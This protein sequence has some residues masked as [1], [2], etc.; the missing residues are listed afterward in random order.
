VSL[1]REGR[2]EE[3]RREAA[4]RR[5][6]RGSEA[7]R[8]ER[9]AARVKDENRGLPFLGRLFSRRRQGR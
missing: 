7:E 3:R 5:A 1:R 9:R 8:K 2:R 4:I 6:A